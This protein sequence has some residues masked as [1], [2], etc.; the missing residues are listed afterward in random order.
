[1]G[2]AVMTL[3]RYVMLILCVVAI[4]G[5]FS[6]VPTKYESTTVG[7]TVGVVAGAILTSCT[8]MGLLGGVVV[9]GLI[10]HGME[11]P[12]MTNN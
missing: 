7:A 8:P 12:A 6:K 2:N 9:G 5:Y 1:M 3:T 4:A 10:G 11:S